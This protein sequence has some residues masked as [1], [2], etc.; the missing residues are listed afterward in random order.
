M[1]SLFFFQNKE[2]EIAK[3]VS[4]MCGT[5]TIYRQQKN[6]SFGAHEFRDGISYSE[7]QQQKK[8]VEYSEL[9]SLK[10]GEC[11]VLLPEPTVRIA[12]IQAPEVKIGDK[13][14]GF[15]QTT[16]VTAKASIIQE[17]E[18][19]EES[20]KERVLA[21]PLEYENLESK[22]AHNQETLSED[23]ARTDNNN[24]INDKEIE[25]QRQVSEGKSHFFNN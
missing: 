13:H 21:E 3:M 18:R 24:I 19:I 2:P 25:N 9:A 7:Q 5:E 4:N 23:K 15:I 12:K 10:P 1:A 16:T 6:T 14:L 22:L 8:L 17:E 20:E 11:F